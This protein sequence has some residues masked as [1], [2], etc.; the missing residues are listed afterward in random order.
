MA[1]ASALKQ[2]LTCAT[3]LVLDVEFVTGGHVSDYAVVKCCGKTRSVVAVWMLQVRAVTIQY[4]N[5]SSQEIMPRD[6]EVTASDH[7]PQFALTFHKG[8]IVGSWNECADH[9]A[10]NRW[11]ISQ[12]LPSLEG[13]TWI[14][15][16][17]F[18]KKLKLPIKHFTLDEEAT[19][20]GI[21][22]DRKKLA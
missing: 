1:Q 10:F 20:F 21:V 13:V 6:G 15:C 4:K 5:G 7:H 12:G 14:C 9:C 3:V 18:T 8:A 16:M 17:R 11:L 2:L 22:F 19:H